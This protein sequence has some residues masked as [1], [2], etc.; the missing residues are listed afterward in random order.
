MYYKHM[1]PINPQQMIIW[2]TVGADVKYGDICCDAAVCGMMMYFGNH[3][4]VTGINDYDWLQKFY[5]SEWPYWKKKL[6][7]L[8][9]S[10]GAILKIPDVPLLDPIQSQM[11]KRYMSYQK[12]I[13]KTT[14]RI[15]E[16]EIA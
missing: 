5:D 15:T 4:P 1:G 12:H 14:Q 9:R 13:G 16:W 6:P 8:R 10:L 2:A 7:E 11:F 3:I